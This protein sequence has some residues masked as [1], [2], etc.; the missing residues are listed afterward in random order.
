MKALKTKIIIFAGLL[1]IA[2]V[3][4]LLQE[5]TTVQSESN[6]VP[7]I[8]V[9]PES[10][11][12]SEDVEIIVKVPDDTKVYYT[13]DGSVPDA[14]NGIGYDDA[15]KLKASQNE[16]IHTYRFKFYFKDGTESEVI[17]RTYFTGR[18]IG[19]RY[20]TM[21]LHLTGDPDGLFGYDNG[22]FVPGRLF[23]EF[24]EANPDA[25]WGGGVEA[26]FNLKGPEYE[27]EVYVQ[28]FDQKGNTLMENVGGVRIIGNATRMKNQKSFKLYARSE[29]SIENEFEYTLFEDLR[30]QDTNIVAP[31]HKRLIVRSAGTDNGFA[32]LRS[33]LVG[34]LAAEAGFLDVMYAKPVCVYINGQY[35]GIYWIENAFDRQYFENR[36]GEYTGEFMVLYGSDDLKDIEPTL[37]ADELKYTEEFNAT[38]TRLSQMDLTNEQNYQEVCNFIDVQNY[39]QYFAIENYVANYDWPTNNEKVYRYISDTGEYQE[40]TVFDGRYRFLLMDVDY[41]FGLFTQKGSVGIEWSESTLDRIIS[42]DSPLFAALMEREDCRQYFVNYTCDLINGAMQGEYVA[43][44]VDEM[45][46]SRYAELYNVLENTDMLIE[47]IWHWE[48]D[49]Y[50]TISHVDSEIEEIKDFAYNRCT[51]VYQD[52]AEYFSYKQAYQL[53]VSHG[54]SDGGVRINSI[55]MNQTSF[56]GIYYGEIPIC[57]EP[58]LPVNTEFECWI[59]NGEER[60]EGQL[61]LEGADVLNGNIDVMLIANAVEEPVLQIH[62]VCSEGMNDY[63]EI[64]NYSDK[65]L[66]TH[67]YFLSDNDEY[68]QYSLP[69]LTLKPGEILRIYGKNSMDVESLGNFCMNFNLSRGETLT[70]SKEREVV[71]YI[72]IPDMSEGSV[73]VKDFFAGKFYEKLK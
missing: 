12:F 38:Y 25:H 65:E 16:E 37:S 62:A 40:G 58:I 34:K 5:S 55:N 20:T 30:N 31:Q 11:F 61:V 6:I 3:S 26:N 10:G 19:N 33:E 63:V 29:Y 2:L 73:Y 14:E 28:L 47:K 21:V 68:T 51:A 8:S 43:A 15:I 1:L 7:E 32:Y 48:R 13:T 71:E 9:L 23:D 17:S 27:R 66:P 52:F 57:L 4:I 36:Y 60:Y 22:I 42:D 46:A 45:H 44:V 59:V 53:M 35:Q 64:I 41:G 24:V 50:Q 54:I 69:R 56:A 49:S 72:E 18:N 70:L 67:N 39:L